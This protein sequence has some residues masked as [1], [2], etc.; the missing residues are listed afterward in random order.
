MEGAARLETTSTGS[1]ARAATLTP[2]DFAIATADSLSVTRKPARE[3]PDE[4]GW[5]RGVLVFR[6]ATLGDAAAEFNR[7][8]KNKIAIFD[9]AVASLTISGTFPV[10]GIELF[11]SAARDSFGLHVTQNGEETV[12]SHR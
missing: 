3:L 12:I 7:Y 11:S 9:P 8:S 10:G 4:L 6:R 5:R 1:V 2:G